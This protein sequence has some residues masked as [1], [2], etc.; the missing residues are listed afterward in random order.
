MSYPKNWK[1]FSTIADRYSDEQRQ[2]ANRFAARFRLA[3]GFQEAI[4]EKI[5]R[6]TQHGFS[7]LLA[8][9]L[10]ANAVE[11]CAKTFH[12]K[13]WQ[14]G[15]ENEVLADEL[16]LHFPDFLD[17]LIGEARGALKSKLIRFKS[18]DS[19]DVCCVLIA[20]RNGFAH[21]V[22]TSHAA[23]LTRSKKNVARL[24]RLRDAGLEACELELAQHLSS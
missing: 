23:N 15:M 14:I 16:R 9:T 2:N 22:L 6:D 11:A 7:C 19:D 1:R 10:A 3:K 12:K 20:I 17:L 18:G 4:F 13:P 24:M 5:S 8:V 21:G